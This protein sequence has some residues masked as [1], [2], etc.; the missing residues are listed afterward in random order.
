[1]ISG[2]VVQLTEERK[3]CFLGII[4]LIDI[5]QL[6]QIFFSSFRENPR[7]FSTAYTLFSSD[8]ESS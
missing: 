6:S 7:P 1:V 4:F 5:E 2:C 3:H 8:G